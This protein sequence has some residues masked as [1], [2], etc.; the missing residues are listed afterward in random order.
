MGGTAG[1]HTAVKGLG[2]NDRSAVMW[3]GSRL[4]VG[5]KGGVR[6]MCDCDSGRSRR[7]TTTTTD[8][9]LSGGMV[10]LQQ[11]AADI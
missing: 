7:L 11:L 4:G 3:S 2:V 8:V 6:V 1:A 10:F 5:S 9:D